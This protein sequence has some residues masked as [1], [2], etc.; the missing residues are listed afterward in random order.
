MR[1][2]IVDRS[3][4]NSKRIHNHIQNILCENGWEYDSLHP[5]IVICIGG[6]GTILRAI[7]NNQAQLDSI[8]FVGLHTGTL[9]FLTDYTQDEVDCFIHDLLFNTPSIEIRPLL[10]MKFGNEC[11][12]AFNEFRIE[13]MFRTLNLD[14][15]IDD[16]Y[17]EKTTGSGICISTQ[18]G[19]TALNRALSGAVVDPGIDVIQLSEISPISHK[20]HHSLRNSYIMKEDRKITICMENTKDAFICFDHLYKEIGDIKEFHVQTS[21]KKVR[22]A[23][24][25]TSSYLKRLMNLY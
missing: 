19:S 20:N 14:V 8:V 12:Y 21:N 5:E 3:D 13:S 22:F 10:E 1:F 11:L 7:H 4:E 9:G 24:Y 17:F 2:L 18:A 25:R 23:R 6:D 15:Y 16:E